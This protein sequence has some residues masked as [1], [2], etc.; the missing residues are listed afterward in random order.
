[1]QTLKNLLATVLF[2]VLKQKWQNGGREGVRSEG[3][4][5]GK[6][7]ERGEEGGGGRDTHPT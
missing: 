1:M 2:R 3:R 6:G 4:R 7:G 5:E